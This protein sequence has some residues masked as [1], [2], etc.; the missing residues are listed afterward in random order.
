MYGQA[1]AKP[2]QGINKAIPV[3]EARLF[4][5]CFRYKLQY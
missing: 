2:G 4:S 1:K 3:Y 5:G